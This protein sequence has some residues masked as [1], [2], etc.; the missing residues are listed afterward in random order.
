MKNQYEMVKK[1]KAMQKEMEKQLVAIEAG[2]G[3]IKI[4]MNGSM[5]VVDIQ[6]DSTS[7]EVTDTVKLQKNL[8]NA[9]NAATKKAQMLS[10]SMM[11]DMGLGF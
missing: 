9:F 11:K 8:M 10:A 2:A 7:P 3:A 5:Q 4:T 1:A 6:L